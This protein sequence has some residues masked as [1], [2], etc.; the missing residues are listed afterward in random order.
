MTSIA[1]PPNTLPTDFIIT[2]TWGYEAHAKST[3]NNGDGAFNRALAASKPMHN[4]DWEMARRLKA[5][6][7]THT[8]KITQLS[9]RP[10]FAAHLRGYKRYAV[11]TYVLHN[12]RTGITFFHQKHTLVLCFPT[13]TTFPQMLRYVYWFNKCFFMLIS[14][15][16]IFHRFACNPLTAFD[17]ELRD[18][19]IYAWSLPTHPTFERKMA[20][21]KA[22]IDE[23]AASPHH[24]YPRCRVFYF[25]RKIHDAVRVSFVF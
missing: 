6:A 12:L 17:K 11:P 19:F 10:M 5:V 2:R 25:T 14:Y 21:I 22:A 13:L 9:G 16:K 3:Q 8:R 24:D 23:A 7:H 18:D 1:N 15:S 20:V 4:P